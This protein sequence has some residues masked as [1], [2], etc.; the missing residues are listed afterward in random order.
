MILPHRAP[1][2]AEIETLP[3]FVLTDPA[4]WLPKLLHDYDN[5][6]TLLY[7]DS[8]VPHERVGTWSFYLLNIP[9]CP[10]RYIIHRND[11]FTIGSDDLTVFPDSNLFDFS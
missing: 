11:N 3:R 6:T 10:A 4:P 1:T 9:D 7:H 5:T 2:D 8:T